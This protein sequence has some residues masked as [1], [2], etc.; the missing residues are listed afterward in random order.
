MVRIIVDDSQGQPADVCPECGQALKVAISYK[1]EWNMETYRIF[2]F[3]CPACS[4]QNEQ[5]QKI[6]NEEFRKHEGR[7]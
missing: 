3:M 1:R 2:T 7:R 4:F 6:S 5:K